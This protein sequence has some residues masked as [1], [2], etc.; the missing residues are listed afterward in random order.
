MVNILTWPMN[1]GKHGG[2]N[3]WSGIGSGSPVFALL[4]ASA[5]HKNCH[6]K[7]CWRVG[8]VHPDHGWPSCRRHYRDELATP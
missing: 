4:V 6:I 2:Y 1:T 5:K 8:H 7:G 3:F